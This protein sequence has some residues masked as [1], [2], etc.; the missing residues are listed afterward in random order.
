[1]RKAIQ[2]IRA[3]KADILGVVLNNVDL[4]AQARYGYDKSGSYYRAYQKY[5]TD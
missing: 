5:Y 4:E 2:E 1:M 3:S